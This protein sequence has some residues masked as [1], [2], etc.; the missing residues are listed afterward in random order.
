MRFRGHK[1][2]KLNAMCIHFFCLCPLSLAI[3]LNFNLT[4]L[5]Y[6]ESYRAPSSRNCFRVIY[7]A[8]HTFH[9]KIKEA[10]H[11]KWEDPL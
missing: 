10:L 9:L 1:Q 2:R 7:Q 8:S 11:I 6:S 3:E 4:K 5:A